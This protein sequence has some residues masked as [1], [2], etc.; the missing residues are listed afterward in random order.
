[1]DND[2]FG[3]HQALEFNPVLAGLSIANKVYHGK[4]IKG[5]EK[6]LFSQCYCELIPGFIVS[7]FPCFLVS[8]FPHFLVIRF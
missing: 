3:S 8:S 4:L 5:D 1:L 7:Y 6:P 2:L